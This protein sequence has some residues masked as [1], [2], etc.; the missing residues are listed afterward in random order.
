MKTMTEITLAVQ[1]R[2]GRQDTLRLLARAGEAS[3]AS[4]GRFAPVAVLE[5]MQHRLEKGFTPD[6]IAAMTNGKLIQQTRKY[7]ERQNAS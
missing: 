6:K 1:K 5:L 2:V 3:R 4:E 7:L